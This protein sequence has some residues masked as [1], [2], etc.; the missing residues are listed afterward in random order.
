MGTKSVSMSLDPQ[1]HARLQVLAIAN[2]RPL[3]EEARSAIQAWVTEHEA[4]ITS[5]IE[6]RRAQLE[7]DYRA[8]LAVLEGL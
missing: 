1:T 8:Q 2:D 4:Q 6:T 3:T 5:H 7:A